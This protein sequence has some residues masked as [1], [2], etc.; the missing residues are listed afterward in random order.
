[1]PLKDQCFT[2]DVLDVVEEWLHHH[3]SLF[4]VEDS[5]DAGKSTTHSLRSNR[6]RGNNLASVTQSVA[7]VREEAINSQILIRRQINTQ[8][9]ERRGSHVRKAR[10]LSGG[11]GLCHHGNGRRSLRRRASFFLKFLGFALCAQCSCCDARDIC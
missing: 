3:S 7:V 2:N 9:N 11:G 1:M 8:S 6:N 5:K 4:F 10:I